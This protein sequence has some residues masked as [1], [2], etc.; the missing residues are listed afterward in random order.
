MILILQQIPFRGVGFF[1]SC[2]Q[3]CTS[4]LLFGREGDLA[5]RLL[6]LSPRGESVPCRA[7]RQLCRQP[8]TAKPGQGTSTL[9]F[10]L[11]EREFPVSVACPACPVLS[12]FLSLSG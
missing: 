5:A 10:S 3:P 9:S 6:P 12:V 8:V 2:T 4:G 1:F 11:A 7:Q